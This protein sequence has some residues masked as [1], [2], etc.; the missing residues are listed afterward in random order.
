M[1]SGKIEGADSQR[2]SIAIVS[3]RMRL[4]YQFV[5]IQGDDAL[6]FRRMPPA[7]STLHERVSTISLFL[8]TGPGQ[9]AQSPPSSTRK[10]G[11]RQSAQVED[12]KCTTCIVQTTSEMTAYCS[13]RTLVS[14]VSDY[15]VGRLISSSARFLTGLN[16]VDDGASVPDSFGR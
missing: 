15:Q 3:C 12:R 14:A 8:S 11:C 1:S 13:P 2:R 7:Y 10:T 6:V 5:V 16:V 9:A 4:A